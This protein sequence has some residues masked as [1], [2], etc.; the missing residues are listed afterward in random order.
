M[1]N[2]ICLSKPALYSLWWTNPPK[3]VTVKSVKWFLVFL[4]ELSES[5]MVIIVS[6]EAGEANILET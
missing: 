3:T 6:E 2:I 1:K 4:E 5:T